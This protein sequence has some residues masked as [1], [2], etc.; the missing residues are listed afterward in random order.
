M[1]LQSCDW[2]YN[3]PFLREAYDG[4]V[5]NFNFYL[6]DPEDFPKLKDPTKFV[7][8]MLNPRSKEISL[9]RDL[10]GK[11]RYIPV[12]GTWK[13]NNR[14]IKFVGNV[15]VPMDEFTVA[16]ELEHGLD[17]GEISESKIS[18][19]ALEKYVDFY[20]RRELETYLKNSEIKTRQYI[21]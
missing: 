7:G 16:H 21:V 3:S 4:F 8:G 20:V 14:K 17:L 2:C 13:I 5:D 9:R 15:P 10:Q 12:S 6:G 1:S 11:Y 19:R 18:R